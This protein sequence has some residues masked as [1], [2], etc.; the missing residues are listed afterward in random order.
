MTTFEDIDAALHHQI[1]NGPPI[2]AFDTDLQ[3]TGYL[4]LPPNR[5][6]YW[7]LPPP[8]NPAAVTVADLAD[9]TELHAVGCRYIITRDID[10]DRCLPG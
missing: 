2:P 9:A 10:L 3:I 1:K 5:P 6:R 7:M 8:M 4:G